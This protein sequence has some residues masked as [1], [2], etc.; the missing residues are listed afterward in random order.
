[1]AFGTG[2]HATTG[3]LGRRLARLPLAGAS[4]CD[5]GTG[6]GLLALVARVRGAKKIEAFDFDATAV[7]IARE[8]EKSNFPG[9]AKIRWS[10][11]DVTRWSATTVFDVVVANLYA[12][13]LIHAVK[14]LTDAVRP[15]GVMLLSGILLK[16][17]KDVT[18]PFL[19]TGLRLIRRQRKGKWVMLELEKPSLS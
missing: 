13:L 10:K 6:S 3:M 1:M 16:L 9:P 19:A 7:R 12:E 15:G 11:K 4:V 14:P 2:E 5:A 18:A 8:N 17:E